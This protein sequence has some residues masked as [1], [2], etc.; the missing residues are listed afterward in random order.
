MFFNVFLSAFLAM[1]KMLFIVLIAFIAVRKNFV[2]NQMIQDL[3]IIT[4]NIFLPCLILSNILN[5][6]RPKEFTL[7]WTLPLISVVI[8]I[9]G[10]LLGI[11][12]FYKDLSWKKN[13]LPLASFQNAAFLVLPVGAVLFPERFDLFSLYVFLY[14]LVQ[15][16]L[17]W[18]IGK[19]LLTARSNAKMDWRG[20]VT[21]PI[22]ATFTALVV[23]FSGLR[24]MIFPAGNNLFIYEILKILLDSLAF[25]G[26]ATIPLAMF[27]LGG[28]L[29]EIPFDVRSNWFDTLRVVAVKL[30]LVPLVVLMIVLLS[31]LGSTNPLLGIFCVI[32]GASAPAIVLAL[33]I[34][35]YGGDE[36]KTGSILIICYILN[37]FTLPLWVA[38]WEWANALSFFYKDIQAMA[39]SLWTRCYF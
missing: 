28:L 30:F 16:P 32:Q 3:S 23:V 22:V 37:L 2:P 34:K 31:G 24:D 18:S 20:L 15:S 13:L 6:F 9:T 11:L 36:E 14:V 8:A 39:T 25:I 29:G 35:K 10:F 17:V 26:E 1:I 38:V 4:I 5:N 21:P 19:Y 12:V 33:Q 7:W 27:V